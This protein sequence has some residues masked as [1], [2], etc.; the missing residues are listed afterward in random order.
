MPFFCGDTIAEVS[1]PA[2]ENRSLRI[3]FSKTSMSPLRFSAMLVIFAIVRTTA[4][5]VGR[6]EV[7]LPVPLPA[8]AILAFN[9]VRASS[10]SARSFEKLANSRRSSFCCVACSALRGNDLAISTWS[11]SRLVITT[12]FKS[13]CFAQCRDMSRA[14]SWQASNFPAKSFTRPSSRSWASS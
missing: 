14:S 2:D 10:A 5:T 13:S 6:P 3:R 1:R 7:P 12:F 4:S 11:G 8:D 9:T